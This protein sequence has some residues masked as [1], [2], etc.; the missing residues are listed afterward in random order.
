MKTK[1]I[2]FY[3]GTVFLVFMS[4]FSNAQTYIQYT[5]DLNGNRET[6]KLDVIQLKSAKIAFPVNDVALLKEE[7]D[8][9]SGI[10]EEQGVKIYPNPAEDKINIEFSGSQTDDPAEARLYDLNGN[11]VKYEKNKTLLM[12][13]DVSNLKEGVYVLVIKRGTQITNYKIIRGRG[14]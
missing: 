6:R 4:L 11:L 10:D 12:D 14:Y 3:V 7:P 5:Y 9:V 13:I 8:R 1:I 2:K